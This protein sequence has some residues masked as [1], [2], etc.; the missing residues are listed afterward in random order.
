MAVAAFYAA[1]GG[2]KAAALSLAVED[3]FKADWFRRDP[4]LTVSMAA[5]PDDE[6][7]HLLAVQQGFATLLAVASRATG[8]GRLG[9]G[10]LA[11]F[12]GVDHEE[13]TG[14]TAGPGP[15]SDGPTAAM[16]AALT[17]A[18][19]GTDFV[20]AVGKAVGLRKVS[21]AVGTAGQVLGFVKLVGSGDAPE[22][23][24]SAEGVLADGF[25]LASTVAF[26]AAG[27][28]GNPVLMVGALAAGALFLGMSLMLDEMEPYDGPPAPGPTYNPGTGE[29]RY[30]SGGRQ[31][32]VQESGVPYE[33]GYVR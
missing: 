16:T 8:L 11:D 3:A 10:W 13:V 5:P 28:T 7:V 25:D 18:G 22:I 32:H 19:F 29:S 17:A 20:G 12:T 26:W 31:P 1:L 21:F 30:P 15:V 24:L 2:A 14:P 23:D 6:L 9:E 33:P 27:T 4:R